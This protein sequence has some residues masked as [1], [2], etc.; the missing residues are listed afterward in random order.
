[1]PDKIPVPVPKVDTSSVVDIPG[2]KTS[3]G[4]EHLDMSIIGMFA[5]A[6]IVVKLVIIMLIAASFWS[7]KIIID[8]SLQFSNINKKMKGFEKDFWSD[9]G[10]DLL[11]RNYERIK[12]LTDHPLAKVF[13][14]GMFELL[15]LTKK[16][17]S[18]TPELFDNTEHAS[19]NNDA[20]TN[21]DKERVS[22]Q[23]FHAMDAS[24]NR[25]VAVME[26]NIGFLATVGS[27]APFI[28]L[29]GTV[30]GI[31]DSFQAIAISKSSSLAVVAP[32][33]AEALF[34]TAVGLFAA[35]PAVI[36]YNKFRNNVSDLT[37]RIDQF[38]DE[39]TAVMS[40]EL[41]R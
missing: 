23:I 24:R 19:K 21:I 28:G 39:V 13:V 40:R 33:I 15:R 6:D 20:K 37:D 29:F 2:V 7:W 9:W 12:H 41:D 5:D 3:S 22:N 30:W 38:S 1:M 14:S 17:E 18:A 11:H 16:E 36:F 35:I 34:A 8:K 27:T 31:M 26:Q 10:D 4:A 32:G 25:E